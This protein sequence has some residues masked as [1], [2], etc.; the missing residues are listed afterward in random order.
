MSLLGLWFNDDY[1]IYMKSVQK[2][3]LYCICISRLPCIPPITFA[4]VSLHGGRD[5]ILVVKLLHPAPH[6]HLHHLQAGDVNLLDQ[7]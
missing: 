6:S 4:I 7:T 5:L 1:T 3:R 2:F